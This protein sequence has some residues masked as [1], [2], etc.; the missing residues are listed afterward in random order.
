MAYRMLEVATEKADMIMTT[1]HSRL[2]TIS[3]IL[4]TDS[5]AC[6]VAV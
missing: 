6:S 3:V 5:F 2:V 4:C 1:Y